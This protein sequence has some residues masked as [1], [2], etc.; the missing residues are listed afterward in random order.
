MSRKIMTSLTL[1]SA[2][3]ER[4]MTAFAC[5]FKAGSRM[6]AFLDVSLPVLRHR[7]RCVHPQ[8]QN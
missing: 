8:P 7:N 3:T 6:R 2:A 4:R 1:R 5:G